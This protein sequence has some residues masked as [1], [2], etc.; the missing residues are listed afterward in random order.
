MKNAKTL[1]RGLH[2][3][4]MVA[5]IFALSAMG[6]LL[7]P[8]AADALD[9]I[10]VTKT[11]EP[12]IVYPG[13]EVEFTITLE[14]EDSQRCT[15]KI[16]ALNDN[17]DKGVPSNAVITS[18]SESG[19]NIQTS[20]INWDYTINCGGEVEFTLKV[21]VNE[22][23]DISADIINHVRVYDATGKKLL[24]EDTATATIVA[25]PAPV[26]NV[27]KSVDKTLANP[28]D[29]LSYTVTVSNSGNTPATYVEL[30]DTLPAGFTF[31]DTSSDDTTIYTWKIEKLDVNDTADFKYDV[32]IDSLAGVGTY[33]NTAIAT[34]YDT[35]NEKTRVAIA[36]SEPAT[37]ST[38]VKI[39][40]V[41]G[42]TSPSLTITK[43]VD[44]DYTNPGGTATY[45]VIVSNDGDAPALNAVLDDVLPIG[46]VFVDTG[47]TTATWNLNDIVPTESVTT[48]YD[49][50]IDASILA[51][52]YVNTATVSAD[53][54][55]SI[56]AKADLE[57]KE[58]LVLGAEDEP[59]VLPTTGGGL[60]IV[61]LSGLMLI[62]TGIFVRRKIK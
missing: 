3:V 51:G 8:N 42:E 58:V 39:P 57:I 18:F 13:N 22:N 56:S 25:A 48:T 16:L 55:D 20:D 31:A 26:L 59:V 30:V 11:V 19:A 10:T 41:L 32:H 5:I 45:T 14:Y 54:V 36:T 61:A 46:F 9:D 43:T 4:G 6:I 38:E 7:I 50:K 21:K 35:D 53:D 23:A 44:K 40:V 27:I 12:E 34:S 47:N 24:A 37:A 62:G 52:K 49:V 33:T 15:P 2:V 28:S 60:A 17:F 1:Q 29:T